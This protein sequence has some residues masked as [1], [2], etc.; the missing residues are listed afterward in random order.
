L[1]AAYHRHSN[2]KTY[3]LRG[4]IELKPTGERGQWSGTLDLPRVK[5]PIGRE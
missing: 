4:K 5:I 1:R 2:A 3:Y